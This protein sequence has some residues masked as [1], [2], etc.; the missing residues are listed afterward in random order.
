MACGP[1]FGDICT[2]SLILNCGET[3]RTFCQINKINTRGC[4]TSLLNWIEQHLDVLGGTALGLAI[5]HVSDFITYYDVFKNKN[6]FAF[7]PLGHGFSLMFISGLIYVSC[8][9]IE[10]L[11]ENC[12]IVIVSGI[13]G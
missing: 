12:L 4:E 13:V 9:N 10:S 1:Q 3:F 8:F 6:Q 2:R 7:D 11:F 5:I